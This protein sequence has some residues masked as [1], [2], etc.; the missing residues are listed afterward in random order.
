MILLFTR[1]HIG[2]SH[3]KLENCSQRQTLILVNVNSYFLYFYVP[4]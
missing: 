2:G 1:F 4:F 3:V